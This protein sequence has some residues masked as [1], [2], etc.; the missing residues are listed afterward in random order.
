MACPPTHPPPQRRARAARAPRPN[1][2][3]GVKREGGRP[4]ARASRPTNNQ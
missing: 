2:G 3:Q 1:R 4:R